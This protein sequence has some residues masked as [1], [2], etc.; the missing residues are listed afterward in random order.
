MPQILI[1]DDDHTIVR[2]IELA[3]QSFGY[4]VFSANDGETGL[5]K[6]K[7]IHPDLVIL[8]IMMPKMDGYKVCHNLKSDPETA[9]ISVIMLTARGGIEHHIPGDG[10][11]VNNLRERLYGFDVGADDFLTKPVKIKELKERIELLI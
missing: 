1:I 3:L 2:I 6:A 10:T 8:D 5:I 7:S 9:D 4:Q 11:Y